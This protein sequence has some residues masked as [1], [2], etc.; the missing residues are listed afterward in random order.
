MFRLHIKIVKFNYYYFRYD[1][2]IF[3]IDIDNALQPLDKKLKISLSEKKTTL[4][5]KK[6]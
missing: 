5:L 6:Y 3:I 1:K 2:K 4:D